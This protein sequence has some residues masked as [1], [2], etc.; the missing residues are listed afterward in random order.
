M[1][2][3][4]RLISEKVHLH[5]ISKEC[6]KEAESEIASVRKKFISE[7][8]VL[9]AQEEEVHSQSKICS[10]GK[11]SLEEKEKEMIPLQESSLILV[12]E[13]LL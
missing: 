1:S 8:D 6:I 9:E 4:E 7:R 11:C 2:L 13:V 5:L 3:R 10:E 12:R